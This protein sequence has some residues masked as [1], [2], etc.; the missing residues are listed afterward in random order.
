MI[1]IRNRTRQKIIH[2]DHMRFTH[3]AL[4]QMRADK[5][6]TA[7]HEHI[8]SFKNRTVLHGP[9]VAWKPVVLMLFEHSVFPAKAGTGIQ[10]GRPDSR[11]REKDKFYANFVLPRVFSFVQNAKARDER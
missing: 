8:S 9:S 5:A 3:Q 11:F 7:G 2:A 1:D 6:G 4:T 10:T